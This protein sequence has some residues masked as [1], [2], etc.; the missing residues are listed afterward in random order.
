MANNVKIRDIEQLEE[1]LMGDLAWRKKEMLSLKLLIEKDKVNETI[2]LRAGM[3]L[4]CAHFEGFIKKASNCYIGYVAEQRLKYE[5][6]RSS[7]AALKMDKEFTSCAKSE[8]NSVHSKLLNKYKA[9]GGTRFEEKYD[10]DKPYISTH[11]NPKMDELREIM[12][13]LGI[14]SDIFETKANYIDSSLLAN[15]HKVVHGDKTEFDK[16]DFLNTFNIIM[17]LMENYQQLIIESIESKKYL[18]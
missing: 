1:V 11:S 4:L 15:R 9:L 7:F 18:K 6:L 5:E 17:Q 10:L 2:L 14:E 13:I 16:D 8:K 3:A 12:S